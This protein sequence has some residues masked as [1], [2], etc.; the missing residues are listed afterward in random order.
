VVEHEL[1][2]RVVAGVQRQGAEQPLAVQRQEVLWIP[3]VAL[4]A[5]VPFQPGQEFVPQERIRVA[6]EQIPLLG[7]QRVQGG[8]DFDAPD[9]GEPRLP[10]RASDRDGR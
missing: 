10:L 4:E 7:G 3:A 1:A 9:G 6:G 8:D 5:A 2:L